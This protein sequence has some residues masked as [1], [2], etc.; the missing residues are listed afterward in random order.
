[1]E[2]QKTEPVGLTHWW[3]GVNSL[4][5]REVFHKIISAGKAHGQDVAQILVCDPKEQWAIDYIKNI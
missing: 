5:E 2:N 4:K 1:M 3:R